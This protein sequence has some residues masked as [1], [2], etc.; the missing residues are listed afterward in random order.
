MKYKYAIVDL[1]NYSA[2]RFFD[3]D[4]DAVRKELYVLRKQRYIAEHPELP[5]WKYDTMKHDNGYNLV[6][7]AVIA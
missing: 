6:K 2:I 1:E 4:T 7:Y 5:S 3:E